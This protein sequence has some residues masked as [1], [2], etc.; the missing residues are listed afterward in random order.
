MMQLK[1]FIFAIKELKS[2]VNSYSSPES[3]YPKILYPEKYNEWVNK[4]NA[5]ITEINKQLQRDLPK[6]D[7]YASDYSKTG[8]SITGG[9]DRLKKNL[10]WLMKELEEEEKLENR[11][12]CFLIDQKCPYEIQNELY[13]FFIG[14]P[15]SDEK[16]DVYCLGILPV[17]EQHRLSSFRA[18]KK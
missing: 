1:D 7:V 12:K 9:L 16:Y 8:K 18:D 10:E 4:L 14:M 2:E 13:D 15:F 17:L 11:L 5:L 3:L 6:Y